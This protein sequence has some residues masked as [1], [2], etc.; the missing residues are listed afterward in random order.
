[1]PKKKVTTVGKL[2]ASQTPK[3]PWI[4]GSPQK[5]FQGE[6][7][8][9]KPKDSDVRRILLRANSMKRAAKELKSSK[10]TGKSSKERM[11]HVIED[12]EAE[13]AE[14]KKLLESKGLFDKDGKLVGP[15]DVILAVRNLEDHAYNRV[16]TYRENRAHSLRN[17][18]ARRK[19]KSYY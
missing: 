6:R 13:I 15:K 9:L 11:K 17:A 7:R 14:V 3:M 8:T 4:T 1:M 19:T 18:R 10:G 5:I 12:L 16:R 2:L